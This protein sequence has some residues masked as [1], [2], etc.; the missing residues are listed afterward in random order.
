MTLTKVR[1]VV[2]R[3]KPAEA[4][5]EDIRNAVAACEREALDF[6]I[7][8]AEKRD[9]VLAA[10]HL[11]DTII[12]VFDGYCIVTLTFEVEFMAGK[13]GGR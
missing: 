8:A 10:P 4:V 11:V 5:A 1:S 3:L 12:T 13:G 9:A 2:T 6:V 7:L